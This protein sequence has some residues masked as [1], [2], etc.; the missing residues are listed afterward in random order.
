[1][2]NEKKRTNTKEIPKLT[3]TTT[4]VRVLFCKE[5]M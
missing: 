1:M 5:I 3:T 4:K 2:D